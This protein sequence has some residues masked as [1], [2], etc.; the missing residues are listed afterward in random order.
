MV[1]YQNRFYQT[2]PISAYGWP[3]IVVRELG[4]IISIV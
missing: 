2:P 4:Q 3:G 1:L